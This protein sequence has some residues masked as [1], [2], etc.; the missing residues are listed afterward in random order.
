LCHFIVL[1]CF[2]WSTIVQPHR[3]YDNPNP[4]CYVCYSQ[5]LA[6]AMNL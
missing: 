1:R 4:K 6:C 5:P 3:V 2:D